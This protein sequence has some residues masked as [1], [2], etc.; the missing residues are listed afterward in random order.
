VAVGMKITRQV[1]IFANIVGKRECF[2][3]INLDFFV[4]F[5]KMPLSPRKAKAFYLNE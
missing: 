2:T 1:L 4:F 3:A 5:D